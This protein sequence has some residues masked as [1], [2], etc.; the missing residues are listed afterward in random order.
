MAE[1][2]GHIEKLIN[3]FNTAGVLEVY[4]P[5][6]KGWYRVTAREFRSFDGKRRITEPTKV[7]H[8]NPWVKM[9]TYKYSGPVFLWGTNMELA[10][11]TNEGKLVESPYYIEMRELSGSRR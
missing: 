6:L 3:P 9:R 7:E 2:T 10:E 11:P 1:K 5:K 8:S 4:M